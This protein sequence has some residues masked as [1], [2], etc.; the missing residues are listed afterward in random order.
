MVDL[1]RQGDQVK[2]YL[3]RRRSRSIMATSTRPG[4]TRSANSQLDS[5]QICIPRG[6]RQRHAERMD[7]AIVGPGAIGSTFAWQ[8]ARAGHD[9]TVVG[10]GARLADLEREQAIVRRD[11]QRTRVKV[12]ASL[13][14]VPAWDLVLVTV[15]APQ[16]DAVLPLLRASAARRVMFMFNTFEPLDRLER[17]VGPERFS[18][19]FPQGVFTLLIAGVI[20][21]TIRPGSTASDADLA[22]LFSAAGIPTSVEPDMHS[23]LRSHAAL[24]VPLMSAGV[25]AHARGAGV[26]LRE[27]WQHAEAFPA[28][29][30]IVRAQKN[31][32]LPAPLAGLARLPRLIVA[33]LLWLLS[34]TK[35]L[36]DLGALGTAEPRML[37]DQMSAT[38]PA[39]AAPLLAIRP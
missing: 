36:R 12:A 23:W 34:R 8:L 6:K 19:G 18:F 15:L 35:M 28:G 21:P 13:D 17:A 1:A 10:R 2:R 38:L 24:V 39:L 29:F 22:R 32:I 37:I 20:H 11:G 31:P 25:L 4:S 7:I 27:A 30:A 33:S 3:C 26:S 5:A 16:V 9:V 14:P